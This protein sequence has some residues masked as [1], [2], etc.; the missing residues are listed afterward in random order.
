M[1]IKKI[2]GCIIIEDNKVLLLKK[3]T[4]NWY[5]LPGG[6]IEDSESKEDAAVREMREEIGCDVE[7]LS[8]F[9]EEEYP[10]KGKT[11]HGTWFIAK[12]AQGQR[13]SLAEPEEFSELRFVPIDELENISVSPN[14]ENMLA[15]LVVQ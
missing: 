4:R 8:L 2:A 11:A 10:H 6:T 14:V 9:K 5:E 13:P 12:I 15:E 1:F 7:I 3:T